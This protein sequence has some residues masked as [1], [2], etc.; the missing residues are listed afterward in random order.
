MRDDD[1]FLLHQGVVLKGSFY[2]VFGKWFR[3]PPK[4]NISRERGFC[5]TSFRLMMDR[6]KDRNKAEM[7]EHKKTTL[8]L[9]CIL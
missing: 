2:T 5:K 6:N 8:H 9:L 1:W 4:K 7:R 3:K